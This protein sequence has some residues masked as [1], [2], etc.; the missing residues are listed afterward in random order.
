MD[1][2]RRRGKLLLS[3]FSLVAVWEA[4]TVFLSGFF[5]SAM[6]DGVLAKKS[7]SPDL[8]I[9]VRHLLMGVQKFF[10]APKLLCLLNQQDR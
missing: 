5:S 7:V 4:P 3:F 6:L 2:D 9:F 10:T 1:D 8:R